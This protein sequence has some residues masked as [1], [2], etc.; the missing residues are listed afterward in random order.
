MNRFDGLRH[1]AWSIL[2]V[3]ALG[4]AL[5]GCSGDDGRD[6]SAGPAGPAGDD[7][8]TGPEGPAGPGAS[9]TP[10]ESCG[11]CHDDGSFASA[12][13]HH[14]LDP[15]ET[16]SNV[17]FAVNGA[18]LDVTF[19][20]DA[21]GA[22]GLG[23]DTVTSGYRSDDTANANICNAPRGEPCDAGSLFLTEIGGGNYTLTVVGG[24]AE[25][26]TDYR[27]VF[28]VSAAGQSK[29]GVYFYGNFPASP[30]EPLIISAGACENCHGPEGI[31]V[32]SGD[33]AMADGGE[34]CLACHGLTAYWGSDV[35]SLGT[36]AHGYH[37]GIATWED[38]M[39]PIEVTYP[40]YMPN[41]SVCHSEASELAAANAMPFSEG[42]F[43]C[44]GTMDSW[45]F[46][47]PPDLTLHYSLTPTPET[48]DC[49]SCHSATGIAA[50]KLV[51]TDA[52]NGWETDRHGFIYDGVDTSVVEGAKFD[53]AINDMVDDGVNLTFTWQASYDGVGVDPCNDTVGVGAPTF[54]LGDGG[55][56]TY[57][58][59]AQ[60]DDFI[61]GT[62]PWTR[63][64]SLA[65]ADLDAYRQ[66]GLRGHG[67][68]RPSSLSKTVVAEKGRIAL[69][70][71]PRVDQ[72][73]CC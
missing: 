48:A 6:G 9:V 65:R 56:R 12:P 13:D 73:R 1:W 27:Y 16:A 22:P 61:I 47:G 33:Y 23:Y 64:A 21:D 11:V 14:A 52:H 39:E 10:L 46:T 17:A 54:H 42:C 70:G 24:A 3:S 49:S 4:F 66:H 69:G 63:Q 62:E 40:T 45:D 71:K 31:A 43:T 59:Y 58:S 36:V 30:V 7:G 15:I 51:V 32:H 44:H 68:Q 37:N 28:K 60:G 41:C 55:L 2:V 8:A 72:R 19:D 35:P 50:N 67:S 26:A 38:P 5:G 29:T 53:W 25:A 20:L 34:P 57:R 18:D